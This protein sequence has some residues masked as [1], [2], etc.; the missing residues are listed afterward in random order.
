MYR[1]YLGL[2]S[3]VG[4]RLDNLSKAVAEIKAIASVISVSSVYETEPVGMQSREMFY[5]MA[6]SIDTEDR[7]AQLLMKLKQ[8]EK[9]IGRK[10]FGH[11]LD[12]EIDIDILLYHGW[13]YED[14]I[15]C[16]PHPE[17]EQRRFVLE[18]LN[19]I[20]PT[21]LHPMLGQTIASLL[22][23]CRDRGSV[24]RTPHVVAAAH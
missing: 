21:A 9:K 19:E 3:N 7:P 11:L 6:M 17:L 4:D 16:V 5:N 13:S 15:V 2:G 18:P 22:R 20:A 24:V 10:H 23:Q 1:V 14:A 8:I 12:R